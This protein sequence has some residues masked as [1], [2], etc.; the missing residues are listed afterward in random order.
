MTQSTWSR[1]ISRLFDKKKTQTGEKGRRSRL[2]LEWL[3]ARLA[4]AT[5]IWTGLGATNNWSVAANWTGGVPKVGDDLIFDARATVRTTNNDLAV[6]YNINSITINASNYTL[7]GGSGKGSTAL[8]DRIILGAT[9]IHVNT[10]F[11]N[12]KITFD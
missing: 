5:D 8:G 12:E 9:G 10:G 2:S 6:G 3:E 11:T 4:P 7:T 1:V